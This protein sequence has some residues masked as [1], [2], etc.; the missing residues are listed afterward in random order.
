LAEVAEGEV[1]LLRSLIPVYMTVPT[2]AGE[3]AW[4]W[5]EYSDEQMR[6]E[7][8]EYLA[9]VRQKYDRPK[10]RWQTLDVEGDAAGEIVDTA[11]AENVDL[12]VMSTH[13]WSGMRKWV[14]GS[15][16]ERV[17]HTVTCPVLTTRSPQPVTRLAI[18][19]DGSRLAEQAVE[20]ALEVAAGLGARV[21]LLRV[22]EPLPANHGPA[23]EFERTLG[24]DRAYGM[25]QQ[26]Q[27]QA[28]AYLEEVA[29]RYASDEVIVQLMVVDGPPVDKILECADLHGIDLI[30]MS[31]HG[32][33]G[34]RRWLY[35]SV[36]AQVMRGFEGH[37]LIVRP[38][39]NELN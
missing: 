28:E 4:M 32:R 24:K 10:V 31:T 21:T 27:A 39:A 37:M 18:A 22:N 25:V 8:R 33:T 13:G 35:G 26:R 36:T 15:V 12:I 20:P 9:A 6:M 29:Q 2:Y 3:Y 30:A 34:L 17:L 5:P 16:T 19:L 11:F 1:I 14:L 38:P 7:V 23:I